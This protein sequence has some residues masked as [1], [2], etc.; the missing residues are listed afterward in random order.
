MTKS[1]VNACLITGAGGS[2]GSELS[3]QVIATCNYD[4]VILNDINESNLFYLLQ[5]FSEISETKV[6]PLLGDLSN[7]ALRKHLFD[8][9]EIRQIYHAAAYKHVNLSQTNQLAYFLNNVVNFNAILTESCNRSIPLTLVSTDKAVEPSNFMGMTKRICEIL[10][11]A[12]CKDQLVRIVRFG[13]VLNSS[14]SVIPIFQDQIS[15]GGPVT[16]THPDAERYFMSINEA[17]HLVLMSQSVISEKKLFIL[18]MGPPHSIKT[19]AFNLIEQAGKRPVNHVK[20]NENE[21]EVNYIGLRPGEKLTETLTY[22]SLIPTNLN[23]IW[24]AN[25]VNDVDPELLNLIEHSIRTSTLPEVNQ[26][27]WKNC[28]LK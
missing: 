11:F 5:E 15:K 16:I 25:E 12:R 6:I 18:D 3:R 9:I 4:V 27:D 28:C 20:R 19:L 8:Q 24:A 17:V 26:I 22:N 13:N 2:I 14:G 10:V 1:E 7:N 21:I 23:K